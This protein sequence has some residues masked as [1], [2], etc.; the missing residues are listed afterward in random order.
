MGDQTLRELLEDG[1]RIN[2]ETVEERCLATNLLLKIG[3]RHGK[4]GYSKKYCDPSNQ[5]RLYM[6]PYVWNGMIEYWGGSYSKGIPFE[7]I[8][9]VPFES[10][11]SLD[12]LI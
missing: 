3:Y 5:E 11:P 12:D 7:E 10:I 9:Q 8:T 2:C 6:C 4:S 1:R